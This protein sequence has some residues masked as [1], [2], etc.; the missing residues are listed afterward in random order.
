MKIQ[1]LR[2]GHIVGSCR[3][4]KVYS[5]FK[6]TSRC[7]RNKEVAARSV[8]LCLTLLLEQ[9]RL[10]LRKRHPDGQFSSFS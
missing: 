7:E 8:K 4:Q 9:F 6:D 3:I 2:D 10:A 5:L 1:K